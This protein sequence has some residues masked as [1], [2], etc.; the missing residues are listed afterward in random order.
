VSEDAGGGEYLTRAQALVDALQTGSS[1]EVARLVDELTSLR[2]TQ[3]YQ[4]IGRLTRELHDSFAS[5][6]EDTRVS[7]IAHEEMPNARERLRHVIALTQESAEKTLTAVEECVPLAHGIGE[8]A[9]TLSERW[10]K[11]RERR[12]SL[13]EFRTLSAELETFLT[14]TRN[15][16]DNLHAGLSDVLMAQEFQD[17]TGQMIQR[18]ITLVG[19]VEEKLIS[20]IDL[21]A[22]PAREAAQSDSGTME[23]PIVPGIKSAGVVNGQDEVDELLSS[24]GF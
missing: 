11:F 20:I 18:V 12:L 2:E 21:S 3:I 23:G 13:D 6:C 16:A 22:E 5:F 9:Q 19:E 8:R 7:A 1:N 15:D 24:L 4:R 10:T 14:S 17:L